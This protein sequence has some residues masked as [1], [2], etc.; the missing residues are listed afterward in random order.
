[1][2][3]II[4]KED[5]KRKP[6]FIYIYGPEGCGKT[7]FASTLP[8]PIFIRTEDGFPAG[9]SADTFPTCSNF[10]E[11]MDCIKCLSV[12]E[13][14]YQTLVIDYLD[15]IERLV[16]DDIK[17][18]SNV[19]TMIAAEGGFGKGFSV[20]ETRMSNL[21]KALIE[22]RAKKNMMICILAHSS[23]KLITELGESYKQYAPMCQ[24]DEWE[25]QFRFECDMLLFLTGKYT[26]TGIGTNNNPRMFKCDPCNKTYAA[27]NRFKDIDM[28]P[29]NV[30]SLFEIIKSNN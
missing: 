11:V 14:Q 3:N 24:R 12:E 1:M 18:R 10:K 19:E 2:M 22:L 6:P 20:A 8:N 28:F 16:H 15:G 25:S 29:A 4:K 17:N 23:V 13:H 30:Q 5:Y 21:C 26:Q 9:V 27:K 7:T